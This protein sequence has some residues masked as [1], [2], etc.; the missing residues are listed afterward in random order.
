MAQRGKSKSSFNS[1]TLAM[2]YYEVDKRNRKHSQFIDV[3]K[4]EKLCL[5]YLGWL[6][7]KGVKTSWVDLA[8]KK[9]AKKTVNSLIKKGH[10][11]LKFK[12]IQD[13]R[14]FFYEVVHEVC[15]FFMKYG[16]HGLKPDPQGLDVDTNE[17]KHIIE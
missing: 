4:P 6:D 1:I 10:I 11:S 3:R 15:L 2:L 13:G 9:F 14:R 16:K 8:D 7:M 17:V 5:I 12:P